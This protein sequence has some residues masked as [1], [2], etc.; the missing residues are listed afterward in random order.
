LLGGLL[1]C[2][3][4]GPLFLTHTKLE[5][6]SDNDI[7]FGRRLYLSVSAVLVSMLRSRVLVLQWGLHLKLTTD[8]ELTGCEIIAQSPS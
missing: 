8:S 2:A 5:R 1:N 4:E 7:S 3:A 6:G